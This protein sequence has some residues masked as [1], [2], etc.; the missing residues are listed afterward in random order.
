MA[1]RAARSAQYILPSTFCTV[2]C[3][4]MHSTSRRAAKVGAQTDWTEYGLAWGIAVDDMRERLCGRGHSVGTL[5]Q[6]KAKGNKST[7][8]MASYSAVANILRLLTE[9]SWHSKP[10]ETVCGPS[11][12]DMLKHEG[13]NGAATPETNWVQLG[14]SRVVCVLKRCLV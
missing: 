8:R 1:D 4:A 7:G 14:F 6:E 12:R 13:L 2:E 5:A 10:V 3:S 9:F 11:R